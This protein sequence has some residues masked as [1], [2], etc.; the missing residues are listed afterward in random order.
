[1]KNNAAQ[2]YIRIFYKHYNKSIR[3][4][5][6]LQISQRLGVSN[7][8]ASHGKRKIKKYIPTTL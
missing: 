7:Y 8:A 5:I 3:Q 1:M 2:D 6:D 4:K